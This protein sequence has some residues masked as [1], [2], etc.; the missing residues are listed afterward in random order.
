[1]PP[2]AGMSKG[3]IDHAAR[4]EWESVEP[5]THDAERGVRAP[6]PHSPPSARNAP[7]RVLK[8]GARPATLPLRAQWCSDHQHFPGPRPATAGHPSQGPASPGPHP[9]PLLFKS[10]LTE[11]PPPTTPFR[12]L[13]ASKPAIRRT[14]L[15]ILQPCRLSSF[16][17]RRGCGHPGPPRAT[18]APCHPCHSVQELLAVRSLC[19]LSRSRKVERQRTPSRIESRNRDWAL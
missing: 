15:R 18:R 4:I 5:T 2:S 6:L 11:A 3:G 12:V 16:P 8:R 10:R 17:P 9:S 13:G 19:S 14:S 1:M 7:P